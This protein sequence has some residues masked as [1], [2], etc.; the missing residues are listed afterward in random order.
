MRDSCTTF[1]PDAVVVGRRCRF[2]LPAI[3]LAPP[4]SVPVVL[5]IGKPMT[6]SLPPRLVMR[7]TETRPRRY[8]Y[9]VRENISAR[10]QQSIE[11]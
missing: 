8:R 11:L 3:R 10:A 1:S 9:L 5:Q 6:R 2:A 7:P 4:T